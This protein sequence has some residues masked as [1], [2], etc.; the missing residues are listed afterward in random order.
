MAD[1]HTPSFEEVDKAMDAA[2]HHA[3]AAAGAQAAAIGLPQICSVWPAVKK[4]LQFLL[5]ITP[6]KWKKVLQQFITI[7]DALCPGT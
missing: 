2:T 5:I 1:T 4:A 3:D 7:V 6:P